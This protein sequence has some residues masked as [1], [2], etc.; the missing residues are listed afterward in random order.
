MRAVD[1]I[2]SSRRRCGALITILTGHGGTI[3]GQ[4]PILRAARRSAQSKLAA[5]RHERLRMRKAFDHI[6]IPTTEPHADESWVPF[7]QVWVT[8]PRKHPQR[9][10]YI[11]P[12]DWPE[13]S[14]EQSGMWKLWHWPHVA[15][16]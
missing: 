4:N 8:N 3:S 12:K 15:Y 16:R 6:G 14:G 1:F 13:V 2:A 10:E 11:R 5:T 7:S 9:I